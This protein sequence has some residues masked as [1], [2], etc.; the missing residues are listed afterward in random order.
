MENKK[1]LFCL[2]KDNELLMG[3]HRFILP[4]AQKI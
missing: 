1:L 4:F 3:E 2:K